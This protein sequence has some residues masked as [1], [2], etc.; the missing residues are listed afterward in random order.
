MHN[1]SGKPCSNKISMMAL[2]IAGTSLPVL[3]GCKTISTVD[4]LPQDLQTLEALAEDA[5][6]RGEQVITAEEIVEKMRDAEMKREATSKK[7][8][9]YTFLRNVVTE[10]LN[11]LGE[12]TKRK[13]KTYQAFSDNRDQVLLKVDGRKPTP[14][15]FEADGK[16]NRK[17]QRRILDIG[18]KG[19]GDT[20]IRGRKFD[21]YRDKFIPRLIGTEMITD[22]PVY[23]IQL[24]PDPSHK[25]KNAT[26]DLMMNQMLTKL[27]ID[28]EE[29]QVAKA[30]IELT[31][32]IS[33]LAGIAASLR[34]IKFTIHQKRLTP[35]IWVD[36]NVSAFIDVRILLGTFRFRMTSESS[37]FK[38]ATKRTIPTS[39]LR[40]DGVVVK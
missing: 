1:N 27:W 35:E 18:K 10:D 33:F 8:L 3:T 32:P 19:K 26:V 21:Q 23:I 34:A 25:L 14:K 40:D 5:E 7:S 29:F 11:S 13:T 2:F 38:P 37:D 15:E 20:E 6:V 30:E 22:R 36:Q 24:V 39:G 31:H 28:Q 4:P 9:V 12:T 17:R 16:E